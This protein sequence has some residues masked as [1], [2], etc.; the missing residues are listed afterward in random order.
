MP[1]I[2]GVFT[3]WTLHPKQL[4]CEYWSVPDLNVQ[5]KLL[6]VCVYVFF[7]LLYKVNV[8]KGDLIKLRNRRPL[9]VDYMLMTG[10]KRPSQSPVVAK[11]HLRAPCLGSCPV[12]SHQCSA[13]PSTAWA[14]LGL[15][16]PTES[17]FLARSKSRSSC[18]GLE[19]TQVLTTSS[20]G[21]R[22]ETEVCGVHD[23]AQR[24]RQRLS[25]SK[26]W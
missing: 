8:S 7:P 22:K 21:R 24:L 6:G 18:L 13:R 17:P 14:V 16:P 10:S 4:P 15:L 25:G 2:T 12:R 23:D 1:R 26:R 20:E 19:K 9:F 3:R 11:H 5:N